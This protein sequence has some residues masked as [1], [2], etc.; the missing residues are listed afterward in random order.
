[1]LRGLVAV[2]SFKIVFYKSQNGELVKVREFFRLA[3]NITQLVADPPGEFFQMLEFFLPIH[4]WAEIEEKS[5]SV[6]VIFT[7]RDTK[8]QEMENDEFKK[9]L[10]NI[11]PDDFSKRI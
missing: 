6:F 5:A 2:K 4:G 1:M 10:E 11:K 8:L 9:W 7:P 3:E